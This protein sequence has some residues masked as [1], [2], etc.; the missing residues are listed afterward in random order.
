MADPAIRLGIPLRNARL[1][2]LADAVDAGDALLVIYDGSMPAN[3]SNDPGLSVKLIALPIPES[4]A[5]SIS[6]GV[7]TGNTLPETMAEASGAASWSRLT[8]DGQTVLDMSVG[9][10]SS[11]HPVTLPDT[12]IYAGMLVRGVS[13]AFTEG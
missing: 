9:D 13:I 12:Q 5:E 11:G 7:L 8:V 1:Q 3:P 6:S 10:E 4:F 2:A